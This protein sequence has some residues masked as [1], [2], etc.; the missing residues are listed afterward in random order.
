[1]CLITSVLLGY[2]GIPKVCYLTWLL[3]GYCCIGYQDL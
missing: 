2:E 1:M 3:N